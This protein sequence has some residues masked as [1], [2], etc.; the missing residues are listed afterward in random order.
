MSKFSPKLFASMPIESIRPI[1]IG[2]HWYGCRQFHVA[3]L[4]LIWTIFFQILKFFWISNFYFFFPLLWP[5]GPQR[6]SPLASEAA[7]YTDEVAL[8]QIWQ[9]PSRPRLHLARP[10][11]LPGRVFVV[12][13]ALIVRGLLATLTSQ[14]EGKKF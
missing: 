3:R 9:D 4:A 12:P 6:H 11:R 2:N 13:S 7:P 5:V 8:A 14:S 10:W 1:L